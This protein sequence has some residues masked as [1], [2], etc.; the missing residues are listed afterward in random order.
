MNR[1][2]LVVTA[3]LFLTVFIQGSVYN[4]S[5]ADRIFLK[6]GEFTPAPK[7]SV[8]KESLSVQE[9]GNV[10]V[11]IQ[12]DHLPNKTE[13]LIFKKKGIHLLEYIPNKAWIASVPSAKLS[14]SYEKKSVTYLAELEPED[15]IEPNLL[16][17]SEQNEDSDLL[18]SVLFFSDISRKEASSK[19]EKYGT[20]V[21]EPGSKNLPWLVQI[22]SDE[23]KNL[24][25]S[26]SV[27][28]IEP[29]NLELSTLND[30]ARNSTGADTVQ[31]SPY[32]LNGSGITVALW[33]EGYANHTDFNDRATVGDPGEGSTGDH[34]THVA[35]TILGNGSNSTAHGGAAR[36][37]KGMAPNATLLTYE[38]PGSEDEIY[39]ESNDSVDKGAIISHNSWKVNFLAICDWG[40]YNSWSRAYDD[41]V[42]GYNTTNSQ[43]FTV[44]FSGGNERGS[45]SDSQCNKA[46]SP[47]PYNTTPIPS[48]AKN[49]IA[50]GAVNSNDNSMTSFSSFGPTDDGRLKPEVVA[51][52]EQQGGDN[53]I[54]STYP[55]G[56]YAITQGT[57]QAAPV[58]SGISTL[59]YKEYNTTHLQYPWP[60]TVKA[61]LIHTALDLNETGPDYATGYG[62]VNATRAIDLIRVDNASN[63]S[64]YISERN[65]SNTGNRSYTFIFNGTE[66]K[67]SLA[68]DDY[69]GAPSASKE[70]V[71]DLDL[72][73]IAPNGSRMYPWTLNKSSPSEPAVRNASN[74]ID[75]IEQVYVSNPGNGTWT[76][77]V[78]GTS[79]PY[80]PENY[81]LVSSTNLNNTSAPVVNVMTAN[82]TVAI[83]KTP[84]IRFNFTDKVNST[85]K[86]TLYFNST[87]VSYNGSVQNNTA[88]NLTV[89]SNQEDG[90][91]TF[92][93]NVSDDFQETKSDEYNLVIETAPTIS[94]LAPENGTRTNNTTILFNCSA[95][96]NTGLANMTL[97]TNISGSWENNTTRDVSG[98]SNWTNW[99]LSG[100]SN[101]SYVWNCQVNDTKNYSGFADSNYTL[102]I[103]QVAPYGVSNLSNASK[104]AGWIYWNWT[105]PN[106]TDFNYTEVWLNNSWLSNTSNNYY[107]STGLIF[108]TTYEIGLRTVDTIG[109]R[110]LTF[111]NNTT[112]TTLDTTVPNVT[113]QSPD[114]STSTTQSSN[115]FN[116]SATDNYNLSN[117]I[118]YGDFEG[119][120]TSVE[121]KN[122]SGTANSSAFTVDLSNGEYNWNCKAVDMFNQSAFAGSNYTIT[123]KAPSTSSTGGGGGGGGAGGIALPQESARFGNIDAGETAVKTFSNADGHTIS[124]MELTVNKKVENAIIT[125][126]KYLDR[127]AS[128][129]EPENPAFAYL[130]IEPVNFESEDI[131][132]LEISFRINKSWM[133]SNNV[134]PE[135]VIFL[136]DVNGSW[137]NFSAKE[138]YETENAY[139][140]ETSV[141]G[142]SK[143]ASS[144]KII[145][146][147]EPEPE[148]E[149]EE[150][151]EQE[152]E[153]AEN[154]TE[155]EGKGRDFRNLYYTIL[156]SILIISLIIAASVVKYWPNSELD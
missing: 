58:V 69:P 36:Q 94:L 22:N 43:K 17:V 132:T 98:T 153:A 91:Y 21:S 73:V 148:P 83:N 93:I 24:A 37:W 102:I 80:S 2:V 111:V 109:N 105:N 126:I 44:V 52:G 121:T 113:L 60:S 27:F 46:D 32:F 63:K 56:T 66:L 54:T 84:I 33:D 131:E 103:D 72:V 151:T 97:Y 112:N 110:N 41:I 8:M 39:D 136:R 90:N 25:E 51:P 143:F 19:I 11:L 82:N 28:W 38:W 65:V 7:S 78:N 120:W 18:I 85:A 13:R 30:G 140:F 61:V 87:N 116:C 101:G 135:E 145:K 115:V 138:T 123:K 15:K 67:I 53:G 45:S 117:I 141:P 42:N 48:T 5:S 3:V 125:V 127:P 81:S 86:A 79:V 14:S 104:D 89:L 12:F 92:W 134:S 154:E 142:L 133:N 152:T 150:I 107:N 29:G 130:S 70:L 77:T 76:V 1:K 35:G 71:N 88:T 59:M 100:I 95:T 6:S 147:P 10:H 23:L 114:D 9:A 124:R 122:V 50:V 129:A 16:R 34:A 96:D 31:H 149:Q 49:I 119:S 137:T 55:T 57:S 106:N 108:N 74:E 62:I 156:L 20:L 118:L 155:A 40:N 99:T 75:N 128:V 4:N 146:E 144:F 68:W 26:G 64:E 47:Y 139:N